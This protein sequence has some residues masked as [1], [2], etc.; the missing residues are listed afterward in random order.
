M[1]SNIGRVPKDM[2]QGEVPSV[3][4]PAGAYDLSLKDPVCGM[5]VTIRSPHMAMH[6]GT[7][8]YFCSAGC[9][10]KFLANPAKYSIVPA[11]CPRILCTGNQSCSDQARSIRVPCTRR[12]AKSALG[13]ARFAA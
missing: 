7:P 11:Q 13:L 8:V 12:Y 2:T 10:T 6:K 4:K 9:K 3:V 1:S 5:S